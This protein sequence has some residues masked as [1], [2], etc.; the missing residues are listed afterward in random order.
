M[1][2]SEKKK[3][4]GVP[5]G[6]PISAVILLILGLIARQVWPNIFT[7]EQMAGNVLLAAIPF[8]LVFAAII[9][10]FMSLVWYASAK[11]GGNV[12]EKTYRPIEYVLIGGILLG[13]LLMFQPWVFELFRVGFF[14][15]LG[16]TLGFILWSHV[17]PKEED[18]AGQTAVEVAA[19]PERTAVD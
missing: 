13:I 16:S 12:P 15:L 2:N 10:A 1:E 5:R 11:L 7:E 4:G 3:G 9:I 14:L 6:M 17:T 18:Q 8:I 19:E